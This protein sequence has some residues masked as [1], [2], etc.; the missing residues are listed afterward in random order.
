MRF[1]SMVKPLSLKTKNHV[2]I[3]EFQ[4]VININYYYHINNFYTSNNKARLILHFRPIFGT[5]NLNASKF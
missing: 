1:Y 2:L 4:Q 3:P 5:L